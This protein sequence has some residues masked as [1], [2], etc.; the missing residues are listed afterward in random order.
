[1]LFRSS[2]VALPSEWAEPFG[3][4]LIE[5]VANGTVAV[6]S[7]IGGIPEV[8]DHTE[9]YLFPPGDA[10]ALAAKIKYYLEADPSLYDEDIRELQ[11]LFSRYT[12]ENCARSYEKFFESLIVEKEDD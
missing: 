6:G 5:A 11:E 4:T 7:N 2:L 10:A 12:A 8:F 3:R 1:M 9:K